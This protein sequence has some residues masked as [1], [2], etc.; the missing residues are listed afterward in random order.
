MKLSELDLFDLGN[1][2]A[3]DASAL[4]LIAEVVSDAEPVVREKTAPDGRATYSAPVAVK[5]KNR[6]EKVISAKNIFVN[7]I[8]PLDATYDEEK[9]TYVK[10]QGKV[11]IK[12]FVQNDR[13]SYSIT[14]EKFTTFSLNSAATQAQPQK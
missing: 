7:S 2:I 3:T 6:D 8:E 1:G 14:V 13:V 5:V 12:A 9:R 10:A 4:N 11:W